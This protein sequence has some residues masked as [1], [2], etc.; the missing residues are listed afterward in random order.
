MIALNRGQRQ[1]LAVLLLLVLVGLTLGLIVR[2][3]LTSYW[4]AG[5]TIESFE[6]QLEIYRR[7]EAE[8]PEQQARLRRLRQQDPGAQLLFQETRPALAA[9]SLQQ[10]V[11]QL[12]AQAGGQ[13]SSTQILTRESSP[14]PI[15]EVGLRVHM[16]GDT[17][18]L[19]RTLHSFAYNQPLLVVNNLVVLSNPRTRTPR[20]TRRNQRVTAVPTLDITFTVTGYISQAGAEVSDE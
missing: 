14:A 3:L 19:V 9:A 15:P 20:L 11:G 8:L 1:L 6:Q 12:I 7:L 10:L 17:D 5:E 13:V 4:T 18:H 2:P 16:R